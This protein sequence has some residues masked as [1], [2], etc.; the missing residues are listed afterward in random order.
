[1]LRW[2]RGRSIR[3][4]SELSFDLVFLVMHGG[5]SSLSIFAPWVS[6]SSSYILFTF[7][8]DSFSQIDH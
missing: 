2:Q 5:K 3:L 6:L 4:D 8:D 1:M 7:R